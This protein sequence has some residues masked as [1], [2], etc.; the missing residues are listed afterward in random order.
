MIDRGILDWEW[1]S[2]INVTRVFIHL[3]LKANYKETRYQGHV[4]PRGSLV[5]GRKELALQTGLSEQ[6]V[7]TALD[8]LKRTGEVTIQSTNKFSVINVVN[9]GKY[10]D[11]EEDDNQQNNQQITNNQPTTNQQLTTSKQRNKE[12]KE[13]Y[14]EREDKPKRFIPPTL[15]EVKAYCSCNGYNVDCERFV[16]FYESNGWKV[17]KNKMKDWKASVRGW[18]SRNKAEGRFITESEPKEDL[19]SNSKYEVP[20]FEDRVEKAKRNI[21]VIED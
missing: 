11:F 9:W 4:I 13:Q 10:Q 20:V 5:V 2:D 18:H 19:L 3:L 1:Y 17:G 8:K 14:I 16:A 6:S 7:R 15:E 12:T 21:P